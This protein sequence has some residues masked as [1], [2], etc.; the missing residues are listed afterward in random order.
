MTSQLRLLWIVL[1]LLVLCS[2]CAS[3]SANLP[4]D[5]KIIKSA[6]STV[7][8]ETITFDASSSRDPEGGKLTF[9]WTFFETGVEK[10]GPIVTYS[11]STP[12]AKYIGLTVT[13]DQ[14]ATTTASAVI[15]VKSSDPSATPQV[16]KTTPV[17]TQ[18]FNVSPQET[19]PVTYEPT[20]AVPGVRPRPGA[21]EN[22][23]DTSSDTGSRASQMPAP[24]PAE[25]PLTGSPILK[26]IIIGATGLVAV[27]LLAIVLLKRKR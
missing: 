23:M 8:G 1:C 19:T 27:V 21:G 17:P 4:P 16:T 26:Y 6:G 9:L 15:T 12:G 2:I 18:A 25:T 3:V 7:T 22:N 14:G 20:M 13:D 10:S 11:Y 24:E 5:V